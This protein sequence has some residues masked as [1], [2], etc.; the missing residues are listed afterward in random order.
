M[1]YMNKALT[2]FRRRLAS[3]SAAPPPAPAPAATA[4]AAT[5]WV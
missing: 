4:A 5:G 2:T 3:T 1:G